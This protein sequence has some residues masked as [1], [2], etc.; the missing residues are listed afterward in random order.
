MATQSWPDNLASKALAMYIGLKFRISPGL[1]M[2]RNPPMGALPFFN[3]SA[4]PDIREAELGLVA[5]EMV[6]HFVE[7]R[8]PFE[9]VGSAEGAI[10]DLVA[11]MREEALPSSRMALAVD[12]NFRFSDEA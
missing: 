9:P 6:G 3:N 4:S 2:F 5:G 11:A 8:I 1:L 10:D 7:L 12:K